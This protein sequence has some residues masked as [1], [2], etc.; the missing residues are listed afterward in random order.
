MDNTFSAE[1]NAIATLNGSLVVRDGQEYLTFTKMDLQVNVGGGQVRLENLFN[2]D[3]V[4]R[5]FIHIFY[6]TSFLNSKVQLQDVDSLI[7]V[8]I[9]D[10]YWICNI[11]AISYYVESELGC[12]KKIIVWVILKYFI[13]VLHQNLYMYLKKLIS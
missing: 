8:A 2:G 9:T 5:K 12:I 4:L 6:V 3:K 7:N 10:K 1:I 11:F 13:W